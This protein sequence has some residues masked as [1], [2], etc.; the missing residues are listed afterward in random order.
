MK[1][2]NCKKTIKLR[3][4][5]FIVRELNNNKI[6]SEKFVHKNC[7]DTYDNYIKQNLITPEQKE[8]M[9]TALKSG[10]ELIKRIKENGGVEI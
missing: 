7:Q 10:M 9:T 3:E 6:V 1:C 2:H 5:Y 4:N 8:Q